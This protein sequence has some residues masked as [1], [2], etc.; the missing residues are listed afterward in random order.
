MI[1]LIL[2]IA[3]TVA[4]TVYAELLTKVGKRVERPTH[5]HQ[6]VPGVLKHW[7]G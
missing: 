4:V 3:V 6:S 5:R 1:E 2:I 7:E